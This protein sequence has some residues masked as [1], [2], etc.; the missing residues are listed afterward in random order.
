MMGTWIGIAVVVAFLL[1]L[2]G[3]GKKR[4][5]APEDDVTTPI[6][7]EELHEAERDVQ[8]AEG[9]GDAD[10]DWGPGTS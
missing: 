9:T 5:V 10:D 4:P 1:W 8:E 7:R 6:D 2:L 3:A